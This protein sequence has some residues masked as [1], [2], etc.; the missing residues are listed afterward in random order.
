MVKRENV[1]KRIKDY[2]P[3]SKSMY[4]PSCLTKLECDG[5][6][7]YEDCCN[8]SIYSN[9]WVCPSK[10]YLNPKTGKF[11]QCLCHEAKTFW[12]D[13]GDFFSGDEYKMK[14]E[15]GKEIEFIHGDRCY[16]AFNSF[17]KD[18]EVSIY[19][20]GLKRNIYFHPAWCF[21]ALKPGI[22]FHY[23]SDRMGNVISRSWKW[24]FL[25][26]DNHLNGYCVVWVSPLKM[27]VWSYKQFKRKRK[28]YKKDP[29]NKF[30]LRELYEEFEPLAKWDKRWWRSFEK[31]YLSALYPRL[32]KEVEKNY[33]NRLTN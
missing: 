20:T 21:W 9:K 14:K 13:D 15:T 19:G 24:K 30:T 6:F 25:K 3:D 12:N 11:Q 16:A 10:G 22:E 28:N 23:K 2:H 18:V 26:K 31:W 5:L 7:H 27:L 29:T 4:C 32:K 17:A 33:Q 8:S 1:I